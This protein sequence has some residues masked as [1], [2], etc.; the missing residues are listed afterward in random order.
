MARRT[1]HLLDF[2]L[3]Q[4]TAMVFPVCKVQAGL[5]VNAGAERFTLTRH[6]GEVTCTR[7][8]REARVR[9]PDQCGEDQ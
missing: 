2:T 1:V 3:E 6:Y 5:M 4:R 8:K 7:C 9:Y